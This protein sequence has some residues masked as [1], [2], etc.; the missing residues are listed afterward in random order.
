MLSA[1]RV[2]DRDLNH[3]RLRFPTV[4]P[5]YVPDLLPDLISTF[6]DRSPCRPVPQRNHVVPSHPVNQKKKSLPTF[7]SHSHPAAIKRERFPIPCLGKHQFCFRR[8]QANGPIHST[9]PT[10]HGYEYHLF[11]GVIV[12]VI[13][14]VDNNETIEDGLLSLCWFIYTNHVYKSHPNTRP[15]NKADKSRIS[16]TAANKDLEMGHT[17]RGAI[18]HRRVHNCLKI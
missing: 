8:R 11:F 7:S 13:Y 15:P 2:P 1:A 4:F 16:P 17:D 9:V 5:T 14:F 3:S 18:A 6:S 12:W 10:H